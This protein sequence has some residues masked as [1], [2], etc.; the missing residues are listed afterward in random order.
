MYRARLKTLALATATRSTHCH[1]PAVKR[2]A[3]AHA[4]WMCLACLLCAWICACAHGCVYEHAAHSH[5][6]PCARSRLCGATHS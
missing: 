1:M 4:R 2:Q 3:H 6:T 5:A